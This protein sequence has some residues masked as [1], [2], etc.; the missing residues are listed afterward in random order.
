MNPPCQASLARGTTHWGTSPQVTADH[1][2]SPGACGEEGALPVRG[3]ALSLWAREH[4]RLS[5][6]E[7]AGVGSEVLTLSRGPFTGSLTL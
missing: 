1:G 6:A 2:W 4:V 5:G 7:G 3:L